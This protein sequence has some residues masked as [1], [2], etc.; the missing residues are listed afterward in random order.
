MIEEQHKATL[1]VTIL[2]QGDPISHVSELV[3]E[4]TYILPKLDFALGDTGHWRSILFDD[5]S[6]QV[7]VWSHEWPCFLPYEENICSEI[8]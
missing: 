8:K 2:K 3:Q 4:Y 6:G 7:S 5:G 1:L